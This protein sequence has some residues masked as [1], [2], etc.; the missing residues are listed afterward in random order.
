MLSSRCATFIIVCV[1]VLFVPFYRQG[2]SFL[3]AGWC[4]GECW[5]ECLVPVCRH[6]Q[7]FWDRALPPRGE[8][9]SVWGCFPF[10]F[11]FIIFFQA[12]TSTP[13]YQRMIGGSIERWSNTKGKEDN[14]IILHVWH[15]ADSITEEHTIV[16][17]TCMAADIL[18]RLLLTWAFLTAKHLR[19]YSF[20]DLP[21]DPPP[22]LDYAAICLNAG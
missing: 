1:C 17:F 10:C 11:L 12:S 18:F 8:K 6:R 3:S 2:A 22:P 5:A 7:S 21:E 15:L 16:T 20:L 19:Q 13:A 14:M 4:G 9:E